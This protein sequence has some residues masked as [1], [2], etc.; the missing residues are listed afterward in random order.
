MSSRALTV[1]FIQ[2]ILTYHILCRIKWFPYWFWRRRSYQLNWQRLETA[3]ISPDVAIFGLILVIKLLITKIP[4]PYQ[5]PCK[6][7][8]IKRLHRGALCYCIAT[9]SCLFN[10]GLRAQRFLDILVWYGISKQFSYV[11]SACACTNGNFVTCDILV[12]CVAWYLSCDTW[13][14][15]CEKWHVSFQKF[16]LLVVLSVKTHGF[17]WL[18]SI[19]PNR[20]LIIPNQFSIIISRFSIIPNQFSIIISWFS[21]IPNQFS[22]N[23]YRFSSRSWLKLVLYNLLRGQKFARVF[24][25]TNYNGPGWFSINPKQFSNRSWSNW[26]LIGLLSV[27]YH[28]Q[29]LFG[30][31][32]TKF[33]LENLFQY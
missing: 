29:S 26:V 18:F 21:I 5:P 4:M 17:L 32:S 30:L 13:N 28:S 12:T 8:L 14:A 7:S 6:S 23:L 11:M 3:P 10:L 1:T 16:D 25:C 2:V 20:F 9:S 31:I 24:F 27:R 33:S 22:I 19:N 15:T